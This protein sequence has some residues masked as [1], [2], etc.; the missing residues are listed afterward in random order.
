MP[1]ELGKAALPGALPEVGLRMRGE[2]LPRSAGAPFLAHE[3]HG[4]ERRREQ[5]HGRDRLCG[6]VGLCG[7]PVAGC[8]IADLVVV[9]DA[10]HEP[11]GRGDVGPDRPAVMPAAEAGVAPVVEEAA[12]EYLGQRGQRREIRVVAGGLVGHRHVYRVMDIV[13]PGRSEPRSARLP[14]CEERR[15]VQVRFRDQ[16]QRPA[17][18]GRQRIGLDREL[19]Q[20]RHGAR[21]PQGVHRVQ[22]QPV[23]VVVREPHVRVIQDV[24][25]HLVGPGPVQVHCG[26]PGIGGIVA[27]VGAELGQIIARRSEVVVD[28]VLDHAQPPRVA[29]VDESLVGRR[30]AVGLVHREPQHP[31]VPP[32]PRSVE[33]A[34]RQQ[35]DEVHA[36]IDEMVQLLAR[37]VQRAALRERPD[38]QFVDHRA[39]EL[40]PGPGAV[41]PDVPSRV[42]GAGRAVHAARLTPRPWVGAHR[43]AV[44]REAVVDIVVAAVD[45]DR[46]PAVGGSLHRDLV[47]VS[48]AASGEVDPVRPRRPHPESSHAVHGTGGPSGS[49]QQRDGVPV[50]DLRDI[51]DDGVPRPG[52]RPELV[53]RQC[54]PPLPGR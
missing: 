53:A 39:G 12:G 20:D 30:A 34:C 13:V 45:L 49:Q 8:P 26:A 46:P 31:V 36:E 14:R 1:V 22:S 50:Q 25:A 24:A 41:A 28:H 52:S 35:F 6:S 27:Q 42:E 11:P 9:L 18:M 2:E 5:Q 7:Q 37:R 38:V 43:P 3:Q 15:I 23:D 40:P 32:A 17:Q 10:C 44:D 4:R 33:G 47:G 19:L 54:I 16:R 48:A 29:G 51:E 21:I